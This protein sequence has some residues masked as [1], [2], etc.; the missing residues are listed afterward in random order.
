M[1]S[2][3]SYR[4]YEWPLRGNK[5][6]KLIEQLWN[7][8]KEYGETGRIPRGLTMLWGEAFRKHPRYF[9]PL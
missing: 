8:G 1:L 7:M 5:A 4:L 2:T 6:P 9:L 3:S